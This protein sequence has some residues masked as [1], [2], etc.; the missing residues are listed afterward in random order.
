MRKYLYILSAFLFIFGFCF[1]TNNIFAYA[2]TTKPCFYRVITK[3]AI[4]YELNTDDT[5]STEI[6]CE[7][8]QTYFV[9]PKKALGDEYIIVSYL[10]V[11]GVVEI[12]DLTAVYSTP[13]TPYSIQTFD[14]IKTANATVWSKPTTESTYITSIPYNASEVIYIG[15]VEGQKINETDSGI[16][17]L[18]K[19]V[20]VGKTTQL[21]YIHSS[22]AINLT[23]FTPNTEIVQLEPSLPANAS[24]LAPELV[25]TNSLLI[26]LLLTIP[27][28]I[29]LVLII[30]PKRS[31]ATTARRQIKSLKQLS[32]PDENHPKDFD[33]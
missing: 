8:P 23:P 9:T 18:C 2:D 31:K 6:I 12:K 3:N 25:S 11:D 19:F 30:K 10:G 13:K 32:L 7:L 17:Y 1:C 28:I 26:I 16:W 14:L 29:V 21:G 27:A 15:S 20:E 5:V 4:L 22:L 24:I 33:F